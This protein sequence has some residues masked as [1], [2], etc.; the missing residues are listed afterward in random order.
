MWR[1]RDISTRFGYEYGYGNDGKPEGFSGKE[2]VGALNL[3]A[4]IRKGSVGW[5]PLVTPGGSHSLLSFLSNDAQSPN[6]L[7][8]KKMS[9]ASSEY[10]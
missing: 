9:N 8:R 7:Q 6:K 10:F 4:I 3:R 5:Y 2:T 1:F